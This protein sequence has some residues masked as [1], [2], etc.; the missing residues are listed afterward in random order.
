[1]S[2]TRLCVVTALALAPLPVA[3]MVARRHVLGP[4]VRRPHRPDPRELTAGMARPAE[5]A[6][7][8][9]RFVEQDVTSEPSI[10][11][12]SFGAVEC[13][14]QGAG[15]SAAKSRLLAALCRNC[16][17]PA[18]LVTGLT[19]TKDDEQLPHVWVEAW[20]RDHWLPMCPFY[21]RFGHVPRTYVVFGYGDLRLVRGRNGTGLNCA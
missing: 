6:Q 17:V 19:L 2:R 8:L 1:M 16:G 4:E 20:L 18:R 21:H 11:G 9:Y 14:K 10:A 15:D 7:A 13:L 3:V 5:L 12:V